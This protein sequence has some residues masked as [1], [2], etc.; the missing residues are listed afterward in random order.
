MLFANF[1]NFNSVNA[2]CASN[3]NIYTFTFAGKSYE[4]VKEQK[5]WSDAAACAVERGGYLVKIDSLAEQTAIYDAIVASGVANNYK[6][7]SDA[8]GTSYVWIGATDKVTEG[9]WLWDGDNNGVGINFW[10]GQGANGSNNG[11][12]VGNSYVNWGGKQ[13]G[14]INEPDNYSD[15][16][17]AAIG[18][19]GWP[20]GQNYLGKTG[21]WNDIKISE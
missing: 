16:D 10:N 8:G 1:F 3:S 5:N 11:V 20:Y 2:Q 12:I 9:T 6:P 13:T 17:A 7:L 14:T 4:L 21:E 18:L 19:T 15:Q